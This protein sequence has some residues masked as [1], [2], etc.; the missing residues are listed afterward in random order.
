METGVDTPV[1]ETFG[2]SKSYGRGSNV[3]CAL[4]DVSL[5]A[6]RGAVFGLLGPNGAGKSTLLR[7]VL[8]LVRPTE[9]GLRLLGSETIGPRTLRRVGALIET[10]ALYP[11]L[12]AFETLDALA[13]M[14]G[15][16]E[17][18]RAEDLLD[19]VGLSD[20]ADR[21][22]RTFSLG[23]KQRL[24]LAAALLT[25]PDVLILD[26]PTNGLDPVG[27]EENRGLIRRLAEQDGVT[28]IL[29]SH[30]LGEAQQVCDHVAI[31]CAGAVVAE[32]SV[33]AL[34]EARGRLHVFASPLDVALD[35]VGRHGHRIDDGIAV[36]VPRTQAPGVV[37][38]L[39]NADV[40]VQE[41]R[42]SAPSLEDVFLSAVGAAP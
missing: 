19:L 10:P 41:V 2:L 13:M 25:R 23:M 17:D 22:A 37:R 27:I 36:E 33:A 15:V 29:S 21:E 1:L 35:V 12:T 31:L 38:A 18:G 16:H 4:D 42:W 5:A 9:G 40:D 32:G 14:S 8:G 28:I 11:F 3:V 24:G 20:A 7:I 34:T 6:P 39:V 30:L 26:E